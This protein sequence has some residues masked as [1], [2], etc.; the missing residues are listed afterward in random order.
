MP[1]QRGATAYNEDVLYNIVVA[2]R[3]KSLRA[4]AEV[5]E[6]YRLQR[7]ENEAR[8]PDA[9]RRHWVE[10]SCN[11]MKKPTGKEIITILLLI[12]VRIYLKIRWC[13][14]RKSRQDFTSSN[15][16]Q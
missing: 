10:M 5:A 6:Q 9:I 3:P 4:W 16:P 11:G 15:A 8:A 7:N 2:V 14:S 13:W 12:F 1:R